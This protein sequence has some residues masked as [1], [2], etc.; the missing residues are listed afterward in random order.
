MQD[1]LNWIEQNDKTYHP[2]ILK[3]LEEIN[4]SAEQ[5]K[6][7]PL[8][9]FEKQLDKIN[10]GDD[11]ALHV[12]RVGHASVSSTPSLGLGLVKV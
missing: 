2:V 12:E 5:V 3:F 1:F 7:A 9:D 4:V 6:N 11:I 8:T 10:L